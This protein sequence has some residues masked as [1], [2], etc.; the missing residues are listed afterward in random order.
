MM[1]VYE[2]YPIIYR[3]FRH[4][5]ISKHACFRDCRQRR[6]GEAA[7]RGA[8]FRSARLCAPLR[9][10]EAAGATAHAAVRHDSHAA[11][12]LS[13]HAAA[14]RALRVRSG[15]PHGGSVA[16]LHSAREDAQTLEAEDGPADSGGALKIGRDELL[17][18]PLF[19]A[20]A[21]AEPITAHSPCGTRLDAFTDN[22]T[23]SAPLRRL[24]AGPGK[25][26]TSGRSGSA[27]T[28]LPPLSLHVLPAPA[29][30]PL[31][32]LV[33]GSGAASPH[34]AAVPPALP[35]GTACH[36]S[37]TACYP[38]T[39]VPAW[40]FGLFREGSATQTA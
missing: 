24:D 30:R 33:F 11:F 7:G 12:L 4:P 25:C 17:L 26:G 8:V 36:H 19:R 37:K 29:P 23:G 22:R 31:R 5:P 35:A 28:R 32:P 20:A 40:L 6:C 13:C 2:N 34:L 15:G 38:A 16:R 27:A 10:H 39:A 3:R 21:G 14:A 18:V 9:L 1:A